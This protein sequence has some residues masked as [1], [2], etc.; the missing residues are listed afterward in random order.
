MENKSHILIVDDDADIRNV[1]CFLLND[2]YNVAQANDGKAA[3]EY[4]NENPQTD[5]VVLDVMMPEMSGYEV[6]AKIREFSN[7]PIL[8]LTAKSKEEDRLS[9]YG[10]GGDDFLSKP[11][12]QAEF[13]AKVSSLLRRGA[14]W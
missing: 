9:A 13:L 7:V 11:F 2:K 3:L 12:S 1:L 6:C 4:L 5:L 8:F 14:G 10:S